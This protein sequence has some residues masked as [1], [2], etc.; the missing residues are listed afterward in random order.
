VETGQ[1]FTGVPVG[2]VN[3]ADT[4]TGTVTKN[5]TVDIGKADAMALTVRVI[6]DGYYTAPVEQT[7]VTVAKP[8]TSSFISGGGYLLMA[9]SAGLFS[10]QVGTKNNIGFNVKYNKSGTNLQGSIN[11]LVRN[12]GRTYQIKG[13]VMTSLATDP[14][15]GTATF[16]GKAS[17][18]DVTDP[19]NPISI[20]GNATLQVT[21]TDRGEPGTN[22]S[23]GITVWNKSG[24]LWFS[25]SLPG[26]ATA[27]ASTRLENGDFDIT[28]TIAP[29]E[30]ARSKKKNERLWTYMADELSVSVTRDEATRPPD[31]LAVP[32]GGRDFTP[33][34][35]YFESRVRAYGEAA[36][37]VLNNAIS[38]LRYELHQPLLRS[39]GERSGQLS[40]PVWTDDEGQEIDPGVRTIV[41]RAVRGE[42]SELGV[43]KFEAKHHKPFRAALTRSRPPRLYEEILSDAQAAAFDGN[44]AARCW[45][46]PLRARYSSSMRFLAAVVALRWCT[47]HLR[48]REN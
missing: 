44:I 35:P 3:S 12:G 28:L 36:L 19:L 32:G 10:G 45:N 43:V 22:D 26:P 9:Q 13:N 21:M 30:G 40:S 17:I 37:H 20:D 31:V 23:L 42:R 4:G 27:P 33:R 38:F 48:T 34:V 47:R 11:T 39:I 16:N 46:S 25:S 15:T 18:Q 1:R 24:G 5:V 7:V 8:L 29:V 41:V 14:K 6:V 2:L